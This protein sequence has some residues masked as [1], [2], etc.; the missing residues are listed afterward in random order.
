MSETRMIELV[1]G[2]RD[3][4]V[5]AIPSWLREFRSLR[6]VGLAQPAPLGDGAG[7]LFPD[8]PIDT[9]RPRWCLGRRVAHPSGVEVWDREEGA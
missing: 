8:L 6:V 1:G 5:L 9:Y 3:G 4:E 2:E 7:P